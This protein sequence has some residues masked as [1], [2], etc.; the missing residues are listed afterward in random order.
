M[1]IMTTIM[2]ILMSMI[3]TML[4]LMMVMVNDADYECGGE[5]NT[6]T[7][8]RWGLRPGSRWFR[9]KAACDSR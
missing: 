5:D 2:T 4:I 8:S 9:H 1:M 3:M 7:E 6:V